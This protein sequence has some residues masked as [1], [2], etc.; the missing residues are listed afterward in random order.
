ML[1]LVAA[2]ALG[3]SRLV[4][5][6]KSPVSPSCAEAPNGA[7]QV[8]EVML[9]VFSAVDSSIPATMGQA[10][11]TAGVMASVGLVQIPTLLAVEST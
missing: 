4:P 7:A 5:R 6:W 1:W 10:I 11:T 3:R 8:S 2:D 9:A